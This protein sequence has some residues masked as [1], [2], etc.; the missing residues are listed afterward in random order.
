MDQQ[1]TTQSPYEQVAQE[2]LDNIPG[3]FGNEMFNE[4][5]TFFTCVGDKSSYSIPSAVGLRLSKN[6]MNYNKY[7]IIVFVICLFPTLFIN[8]KFFLTQLVINA[9]FVTLFYFFPT[10]LPKRLGGAPFTV[11]YFVL[12]FVICLVFNTLLAYILFLIAA[13]LCLL[14]AMTRTNIEDVVGEG[15]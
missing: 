15:L 9:L 8:F 12:F 5:V 10:I 6:F 4:K 2:G 14:H 13:A 3:Y 11:F 1:E 7:Y